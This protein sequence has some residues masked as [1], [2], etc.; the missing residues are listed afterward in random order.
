[1]TQQ[2]TK[3]HKKTRAFR[4]VFYTF[5][6]RHSEAQYQK[7]ASIPSCFLHISGVTI[8]G[9]ARRY[10]KRFVVR[11]RLHALS[12]RDR[13]AIQPRRKERSSANNDHIA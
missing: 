2:S 3:T 4:P 6:V 5:F 1:M 13:R 7:K 12:A 11:S 8:G 9:T 10:T